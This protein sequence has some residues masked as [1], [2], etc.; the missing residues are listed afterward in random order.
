MFDQIRKTT[1]SFT[2]EITNEPKSDGRGRGMMNNPGGEN[3]LQLK[4]KR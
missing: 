3:A 4:G 1:E 2:E